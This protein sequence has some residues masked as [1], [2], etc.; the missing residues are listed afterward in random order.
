M[1]LDE[2][3]V[4]ANGAFWS[5]DHRRRTVGA[6][7]ELVAVTIVAPAARSHDEGRHDQAHVETFVG[8]HPQAHRHRPL[9]FAH[10]HVPD[11]LQRH[12]H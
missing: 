6:G 2:G 1:G 7:D 3:V 9:T 11:L 4:V 8:R 12:D 5:R 10:H